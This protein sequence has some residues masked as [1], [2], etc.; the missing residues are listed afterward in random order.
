M[1]LMC[2]QK[3]RE[4]RP[5]AEQQSALVAACAR[6]D[7][8]AR[9]TLARWCLPRV[10]RCI[11]LSYGHG[12]DSEDL[13]QVALEKVFRRMGSF[14]GEAS[15]Y[16]WV[17]RVTINVVRD[18]FRRRRWLFLGDA[19]GANEAEQLDRFEV[20]TDNPER[21]AGRSEIMKRLSFH[22]EG[23]KPSRRLP[24]VFSLLQ[25][26]SVPEIATMLE[27]SF[28]SA[29]KRLQ[30]GRRDLMESLQRDPECQAAL[31]ELGR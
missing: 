20:E 5:D 8:A 12:P 18:H 19:A 10:R 14:R 7:N 6:G 2:A 15:F 11:A 17:D 23:I 22:F 1:Q 26:Y 13:A 16:V 24:L 29:K 28:D 21:A 25:G 31:M 30:R 3:T 4:D 9:E 27:I